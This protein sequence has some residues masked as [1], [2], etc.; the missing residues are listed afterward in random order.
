MS[1]SE[2]LEV[3]RKMHVRESFCIF[4]YTVAHHIYGV[5]HTINTA[6]YVY[7]LGLQKAL[8][9]DHPEVTKVFTGLFVAFIYLFFYSVLSFGRII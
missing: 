6:N 9:L 5:A 3:K 7:F 1:E 2:Y 8:T 4:I